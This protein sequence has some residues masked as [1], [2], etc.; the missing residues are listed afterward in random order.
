MTDARWIWLPAGCRNHCPDSLHFA[1]H[2]G[3]GQTGTAWRLFR[4]SASEHHADNN[5][6]SIAVFVSYETEIMR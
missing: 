4:L 2:A 3:K 6:R 1:R 5:R